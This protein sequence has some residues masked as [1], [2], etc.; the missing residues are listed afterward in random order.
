MVKASFA[1][2]VAEKKIDAFDLFDSDLTLDRVISKKLASVYD[3]GPCIIKEIDGKKKKIPDYTAPDRV[4]IVE[5]YKH[6]CE[7]VKIGTYHALYNIEFSMK[8][9]AFYESLTESLQTEKA[10]PSKYRELQ[11]IIDELLLSY[12]RT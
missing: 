2:Y 11:P 9:A 5:D 8:I 1:E 12:E 4:V 6:H 7:A 3:D 10:L